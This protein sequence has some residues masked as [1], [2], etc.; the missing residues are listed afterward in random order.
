MFDLHY[1]ANIASKLY[2]LKLLHSLILKIIIFSI[3]QNSIFSDHLQYQT[4][5]HV[6]IYIRTYYV[7]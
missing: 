4:S 2:I 3:L 5:T 1:A 7:L 6:W